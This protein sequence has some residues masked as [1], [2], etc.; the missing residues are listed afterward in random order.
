MIKI[1]EGDLFNSDAQ[2][3]AHQCNCVTHKSAHLARSMFMKFPWA[4]IYSNRINYQDTPG[5]IIIRGNGQNERFVIA[6]L[7]QIY[8]GKPK[9]SSGIDCSL[10]R[11]SYFYKALLKI[12]EIP[13]L[14]SIAFP[15]GIGCGAAGGDWKFYLKQIE[16]FSSSL[17]GV[18]TEIYRLNGV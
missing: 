1:I 11:K 3:I 14:K 16:K 10:A 17:L 18:E 7:G 12:R 9:F 8:P 5:N 6:I 4:N 15:W 13:T 2:Y